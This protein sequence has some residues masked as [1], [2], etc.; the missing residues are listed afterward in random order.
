MPTQLMEQI[1]VGIWDADL[2][3]SIYMRGVMQAKCTGA[4]AKRRG[5]TLGRASLEQL[6]VT[7]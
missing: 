2:H 6:L 7:I 3:S 1:S 5:F 4:V